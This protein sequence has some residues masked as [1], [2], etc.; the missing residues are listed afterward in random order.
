M[1]NTIQQEISDLAQKFEKTSGHLMSTTKPFSTFE[2]EKGVYGFLFVKPNK[3]LAKIF[4][5]DREILVLISNFHD[6]QQR[7]VLALKMQLFR[8]AG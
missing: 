7:T 6:L 1:R 2:Y 5:S 3:R 4:S 8:G